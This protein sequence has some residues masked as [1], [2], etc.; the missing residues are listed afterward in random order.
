MSEN[1]DPQLYDPDEE[2][3]EEPKPV[4]W[5]RR[6]RV[7]VATGVAAVILAF[8]FSRGEWHGT[9]SAPSRQTSISDVAPYSPPAAPPSPPTMPKIQT[10]AFAPPPPMAIPN[11]YPKQIDG[12][13][14]RVSRPVMLSYEVPHHDQTKSAAAGDPPEE[15]KTKVAVSPSTIPGLK[16]SPQ[17]D[18]TYELGEGL[19]PCVL[20]SAIDSSLPGPLLCHLPGPVYSP[21]GVLLMPADTKIIGRYETLKNNGVARLMT[22]ATYAHTPDGIFVPL[23]N[24]PM[25]DDQGRTGLQGGVDNHYAERFGAAVLLDLGQMGLGIV[26]SEVS[27]GGNTYLNLNSSDNLSQ[28][29]LQQQISISP[30]FYKQAG[31]TIAIWISQPIFFYDSYRIHPTRP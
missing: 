25:A 2:L 14:P 24:E 19:L 13:V 30:T 17:I 9:P 5:Y 31:S 15:G 18:D 26:Q 20:D 4:P 27:K 28:Q 1:R 23:D 3:L 7:W 22:T 6:P 21:K 16:A 29:I 12:V 11:L 10:A 8:I